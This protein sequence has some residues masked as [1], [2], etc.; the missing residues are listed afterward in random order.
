MQWEDDGKAVCS[1]SY[2]L[3]VGK[4]AKDYQPL[5]CLELPRVAGRAGDDGL[6]VWKGG[7]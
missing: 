7:G 3:P 2:S 1:L 6:V 4:P 5:W